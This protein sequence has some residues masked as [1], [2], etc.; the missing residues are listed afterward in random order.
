MAGLFRNP[1]DWIW[2]QEKIVGS[3]IKPNIFH[4]IF[5]RTGNAMVAVNLLPSRAKVLWIFWKLHSGKLQIRI[6]NPDKPGLY[7]SKISLLD[8]L[9]VSA[10]RNE[11]GQMGLMQI[12]IHSGNSR[13]WLTGRWI[14]LDIFLLQNNQIYFTRTSDGEDQGFCWRD[15]KVYIV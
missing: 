11:K 4:L 5:L 15:G 7:L 6:P 1:R 12:D 13:C 2:K 3:P 10:V 9:V 8:Q 14:R